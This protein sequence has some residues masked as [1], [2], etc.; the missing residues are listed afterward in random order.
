MRIGEL[1]Q[2][3]G[4]VRASDL[5]AAVAEQA[6]DG[7]RL[8]S[9]LITRAALDFDDA[10]R[11]LGEQRGVP[12]A[13]SK[14]LA[15]RDA[16]LASLLPADF[17]RASNALP[18]GRTSGGALIVAAR[19]P[20]PALRASLEKLLGRD[21]T[22]VIAPATRLELLI[23]AA[24]GAPASDEFDVD[25]D[26]QVDL[27]PLLPPL[28][29]VDMLDPDSMRMALSDLDDVRV[30]K[31]P[32]Q[33]G[34]LQLGSVASAA[35][36]KLQP[37]RALPPAAPTIAATKL[38]LE[39]VNT[40]ELASDLA[41]SFIAGRWRSGAIVAIR[42]DT[43]IGY[44]GHGI[45]DLAELHLPLRLASTVQR[46]I[47]TKRVAQGSPPSP[48]QDQLVKVLRATTIVAAPVLVGDELVAVLTAG[49]SIHGAADQQAPNEL[50][51]L[52]QAL[53]DAYDRIRRT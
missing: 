44:R 11:A 48:A 20:A 23:A 41:M 15:N 17:G 42:D 26:S 45:L 33:S 5:A 37:G 25:V 6:R 32:T 28:P 40:R 1:L 12:C 36:I 27:P 49:D 3:K 38:A 43:A 50:G 21:L 51:Q 24:Y 52:A 34:L 2:G 7:R 8:C 9:I 13:L 29:D 53:G 16:S 31:D 30:A 47:Q 14:H 18:I 39:H 10:A 4:L 19:D 22:L 46:A 35:S